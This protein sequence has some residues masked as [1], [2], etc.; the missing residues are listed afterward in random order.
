MNCDNFERALFYTDFPAKTFKKADKLRQLLYGEVVGLQCGN[1]PYLNVEK[2][3][4]DVFYLCAK[5]YA[6]GD[7]ERTYMKSISTLM[8]RL[9]LLDT[10]C[11][12]AA[13]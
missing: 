12:K 5:L 10:K 11:R 8:G 13:N 4:N 9:S 7:P 3:L 2:T 1:I 6:D